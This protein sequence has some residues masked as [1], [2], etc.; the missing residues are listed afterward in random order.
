MQTN[1]ELDEEPKR[2]A[3][4]PPPKVLPS[5]PSNPVPPARKENLF[6]RS[7]S[8]SENFSDEVANPPST[9]PFILSNMPRVL[10]EEP[11]PTTKN[12]KT[13]DYLRSNDQT[14]QP[15]LPTKSNKK[16]PPPPPP[17]DTIITG[18]IDDDPKPPAKPPHNR[19]TSSAPSF[20]STTIEG[21][22]LFCFN[23][24]EKREFYYKS[25]TY[26]EPPFTGFIDLCVSMYFRLSRVHLG[27]SLRFCVKGF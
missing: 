3:S 16:K 20:S 26:S 14:D 4:L 15:P 13:S 12:R 17:E 9:R 5:L 18:E 2:K 24:A 8:I 23:N 1:D 21:S 10:P 7:T 11:T 27:I 22:Q 19:R 25:N 6:P